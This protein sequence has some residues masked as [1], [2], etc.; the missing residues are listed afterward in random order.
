LDFFDAVWGNDWGKI[1]VKYSAVEPLADALMSIYV[2]SSSGKA[3][4]GSVRLKISNSRIQLVFTVAGKRHYLSTGLEDTPANRK[5][6]AR[7]AALIEDD[8]FK[9]RFDSTLEKYRSQALTTPVPQVATQ[10]DEPPKTSLLDLWTLYTEFQSEHLE[11]TTIL[12]DYGKIEKRIRKFPKQF[13]EDAI[14]IQ[15]YLLKN[16]S[17]EIAKRT[18]KHLS[19]C[20]N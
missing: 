15:T 2:E 13:L 19:S 17:T 14:D 6:A 11:E 8:I 7:K 1:R 10:T 5:V 16:Y 3:T 20:C 9:E 4:K 12:R 18:L